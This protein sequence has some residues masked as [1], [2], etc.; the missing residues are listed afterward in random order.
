MARIRTIKP[1]FF[2]SLTVTRASVAARLT[3][4]GLWTHCDDEGRCIYDPR[5]LKAA[6]WP[7]DDAIDSLAVAQHVEELRALELVILYE[8]ECRR[9]LQ[10]TNFS[11]HQRIS[12]PQPS[13]LP[14][15]TPQLLRVDSATIPGMVAV[16]SGSGSGS[17]RERKGEIGRAHV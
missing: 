17:G 8:L 5:L 1:S 16:G 14:A 13:R 10:V 2:T 3:F 9:Y 6:L 4:A 11:E 12:K 15:S 7:L